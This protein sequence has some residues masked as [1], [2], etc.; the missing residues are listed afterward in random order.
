MDIEMLAV[1]REIGHQRSLKV[2]NQGHLKSLI[3][4]I[5]VWAMGVEVSVCRW[6]CPRRLFSGDE[7]ST[8]G[9]TSPD[10]NP[11]SPYHLLLCICKENP[12][13]LTI[14]HQPRANGLVR[15]CIPDFRSLPEGI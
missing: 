12:L 3:I 5:G 7:N 8:K 15:I 9:F 1:A 13:A 6:G 10:R 2:T 4:Y 11:D 14:F